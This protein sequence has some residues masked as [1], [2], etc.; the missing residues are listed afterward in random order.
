MSPGSRSCVRL[1]KGRGTS[2]N[3]VEELRPP[4]TSPRPGRPPREQ[5]SGGHGV[6]PGRPALQGCQGRGRNR[7]MWPCGWQAAWCWQAARHLGAGRV[8]PKFARL[9]S[10]GA[11]PLARGQRRD[12]RID[13]QRPPRRHR[14]PGR[15]A[16]RAVA[17]GDRRRGRSH[18]DVAERPEPRR[19]PSAPLRMPRM[20]GPV[21]AAGASSTVTWSTLRGPQP[22]GPPL[23]M[24]HV[25][26]RAR[27]PL[28]SPGSCVRFQEQLA[29][30]ACRDF[31]PSHFGSSCL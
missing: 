27:P 16:L 23:H 3:R 20:T 7:A 21:L 24:V 1:G 18:R 29:S 31:G 22:P 9:M 8:A 28:H 26:A 30:G 11:P 12:A 17:G 4:L 25:L 5:S 19:G 14:L 10:W 2:A 15:R 6:M 13:V